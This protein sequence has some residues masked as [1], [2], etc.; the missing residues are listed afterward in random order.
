MTGLP[1]GQNEGYCDFWVILRHGRRGLPLA[2]KSK[3]LH[4][5]RSILSVMYF[6]SLQ[7][8]NKRVRMCLMLLRNTK[9][10]YQIIL[11]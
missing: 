11:E 5:K 4:F 10:A 1:R 2:R 8:C 7:A 6:K 3:F 9:V